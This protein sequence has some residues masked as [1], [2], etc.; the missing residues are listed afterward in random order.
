VVVALNKVDLVDDPELVELLDG[1]WA[2]ATPLEPYLVYLKMAYHLSQE[3]R[4]GLI[5]FGLPASMAR[6]LLKF[7]EAAVKIAA[8]IVLDRGGVM[9]GD[10]VGLGKTMVATAREAPA[11]T[12]ISS[13][14]ARG[15]R[16]VSCITAPEA[17]SMPP[18]RAPPMTRGSRRLRTMKRWLSSTPAEPNRAPTTVPTERVGVPQAREQSA[19]PADMQERTITT[20]TACF[21]RRLRYSEV[22]SQ[23]MERPP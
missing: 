6:Q 11:D 18:A 10:V 2:G 17:P 15:L 5:Q 1:S 16:S 12:P 20:A 7:Q 19:T 13:G 8:R 9:I 23:V 3:A 21:Q 22:P 14:P 4:E